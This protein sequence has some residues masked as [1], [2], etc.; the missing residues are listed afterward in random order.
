MGVE[1]C[2]SFQEVDEISRNLLEEV[3]S[4][5]GGLESGKNKS[6]S[7]FCGGGLGELLY[8]VDPLKLLAVLER[9]SNGMSEICTISFS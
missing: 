6:V 5:R 4:G 2:K 9:N 7:P 1:F 8:S 3:H